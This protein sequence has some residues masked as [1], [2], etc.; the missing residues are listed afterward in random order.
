MGLDEIVAAQAD[1]KL[2]ASARNVTMLL[3][4]L[5]FVQLVF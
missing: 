3:F 1:F 2:D 4:F 5:V